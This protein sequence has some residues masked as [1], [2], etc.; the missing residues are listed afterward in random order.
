M[1]SVACCMLGVLLLLAKVLH[2]NTPFRVHQAIR[3]LADERGLVVHVS[4]VVDNDGSCTARRD[5]RN[6]TR[7][8]A[9]VFPDGPSHVKLPWVTCQRQPP[10]QAPLLKAMQQAWSAP[11]QSPSSGPPGGPLLIFPDT[12]AL[13]V[14]LAAQS[15]GPTPARFTL[16]G[17]QVLLS[18]LCA[19]CT[20]QWFLHESS[21][22]M[23]DV[24]FFSV[25]CACVGCCSHV[26]CC[27]FLCV[28]HVWSSPQ[29]ARVAPSSTLTAP[30]RSWQRLGWPGG[31]CP[32]GTRCCWS[33]PTASCSSWT[34][35]KPMAALGMLCDGFFERCWKCAGQLVC[36][37]L[38]VFVHVGM[39]LYVLLRV[40]VS[41]C[42]FCSV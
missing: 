8:H 4:K 22:C 25:R 5:E 10:A 19:S 35:S 26:M 28:A 3:A 31:H 7:Q 20:K 30:I 38:Y 29:R 27:S 12:S 6:G 32:L 41:V 16:Q 11:E 18:A 39:S 21:L 33:S 13:L 34:P 42:V 15:Q 24:L 1:L 36:W 17:L 37:C 2:P 23:C 14:M 9:L 40:L